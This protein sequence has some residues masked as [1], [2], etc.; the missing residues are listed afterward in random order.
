MLVLGNEMFNAPPVFACVL[1]VFVRFQPGKE[2]TFSPASVKRQGHV[3][4]FF[5][6]SAVDVDV[7]I[8][9][10]RRRVRESAHARDRDGPA[11]PRW[12][13]SASTKTFTVRHIGCL[14][15]YKIKLNK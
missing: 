9:L 7:A 15:H 4:L 3:I 1:P 12:K 2:E 5:P 10:S 13:H 14:A 11:E 8:S 6:T